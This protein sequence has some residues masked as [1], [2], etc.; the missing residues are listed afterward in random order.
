[1]SAIDALIDGF[2][3]FRNDAYERRPEAYARLAREGQHPVAALVTC[4][5]SRVDPAHLLGAGPG[6][7]F[8]IRNVAN[9]VPPYEPDEQRHG[10]SAALEFAVR[11]LQVGHVIVLGH[12]GC[13]GIRAAL[14]TVD[15]HPPERDFIRPWIEL[16]ADPC[17]SALAQHGGVDA[18]CCA[19]AERGG[20]AQSLRNLQTF[21]WI[22]E[23]VQAGA[24]ELHGWWF[25]L[26]EGRLQA[27]D[28]ESGA[29]RQLAP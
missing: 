20:V 5:D 10:T 3:V 7:L 26:Y 25:D 27:V 13:G 18:A 8:T 9:I 15:G 29:G 17:R 6:D 11:D 14:D 19:D 4:A 2:R 28:P 1:M 23:A 21:P 22:A 12:A 24:L 16:V